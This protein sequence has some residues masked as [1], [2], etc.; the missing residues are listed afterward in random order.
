MAILAAA[1]TLASVATNDAI[2]QSNQAQ[3]SGTASTRAQSNKAY[4]LYSGL[5]RTDGGFVSTIR[6]KNVLVVAP[7]D[8]VPVLFMADGTPYMLSSVHVAVYGVATVNINDALA[9]APASVR[10][11]ISQYGSAALIW[12]YSSPGHVTAQL[13]AI[14]A[15]RSLSFVF[16]FSEPMGDRHE[17]MHLTLKNETTRP[18]GMNSLQQQT[19]FDDFLEEFNNE[20]PHQ[21]LDM[22]C[23]AEV[24]TPSTRP[25]RGLPE[26]DYPFHDKTIHVTCCGVSVC[27]AKK[28]TSAR[29]SLVKLLVSK[30]WKKV[31]GWSAL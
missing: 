5:W 15:F 14:D 4:I 13:A 10:G 9:A 29:S 1:L 24:Y 22:N 31:F 16:P 6:I 2:H 8:V 7:M 18:A 21:A 23:P 19:K 28:S 30:K 20:R 27:T 26:L 12:Q 25:Y 17:R 11:H 3:T